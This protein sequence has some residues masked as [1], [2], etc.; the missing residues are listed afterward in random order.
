MANEGNS[1]RIKLTGSTWGHER[2]YA[3]LKAL[4]ANHSD[5]FPADVDWDVRTLQQFA[6][7]SMSELCTSF[8]NGGWTSGEG[9]ERIPVI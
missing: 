3:S 6:D 4:N 2:G 9:A 5:L 7:Q 1:S 8:I